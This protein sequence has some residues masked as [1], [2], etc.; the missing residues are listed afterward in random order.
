MSSVAWSTVRYSGFSKSPWT[1]NVCRTVPLFAVWII[2]FWDQS[3]IVNSSKSSPDFEIAMGVPSCSPA[4]EPIKV[5]VMAL[6]CKTFEFR[7]SVKKI[8]SEPSL[9]IPFSFDT[10]PSIWNFVKKTASIG[11]SRIPF[12]GFCSMKNFSGSWS[13]L[14]AISVI[15]WGTVENTVAL[16]ALTS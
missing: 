5:S 13:V 4:N 9:V 11:E 12:V 6:I 8:S 10:E 2:L 15:C 3:E 14:L 1:S 7:K 16:I